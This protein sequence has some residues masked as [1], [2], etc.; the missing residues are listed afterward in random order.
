[1]IS[2]SRSPESVIAA[3]VDSVSEIRRDE[4]AVVKQ[5]AYE[6]LCEIPAVD[7]SQLV[8]MIGQQCCGVFR[9]PRRSF[10]SD[11]TTAIGDWIRG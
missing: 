10:A 3:R 9:L 5:S 7:D 6:V 11:F 2:L 1:M 8:S 4:R